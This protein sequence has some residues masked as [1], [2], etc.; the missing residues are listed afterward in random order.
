MGL[1][2][3]TAD[4]W[5]HTMKDGRTV[6]IRRAIEKDSEQMLRNINEVGAEQDWILTESIPWD[7]RHEREWV[8]SFDGVNSILYV[9]DVDGRLVGQ[10]DA[11]ISTYPKAHHVASLGIAIVKA[12]RALGI[13]RALMERALAWMKAQGAEKATLEVFSTN[14]RAIA[15]YRK[16]GFEVE[17]ARKRQ[18]KIRGQYVDDVYMA[19]WL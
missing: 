4:R 15:L 19:K 5:A 2:T 8:R 18:F 1:L 3:R 6:V 14:D 9:A 7:P 13:G 11:H 17:G 16:M 10:V 12:Y